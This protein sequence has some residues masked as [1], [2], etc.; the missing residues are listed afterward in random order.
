MKRRSDERLKRAGGTL[1][2]SGFFSA[3][4]EAISAF[5]RIIDPLCGP[6]GVFRWF[7][8]DT[9]LACG[10]AGWGDEEFIPYDVRKA[11]EWSG[12]EICQRRRYRPV[13]LDDGQLVAVPIEGVEVN[14]VGP[15]TYQ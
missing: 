4:A 3:T 11:L 7:A 5:L 12:H 1:V 2:M 8:G 13:R 6:A 15:S 10:D 14:F 9:L